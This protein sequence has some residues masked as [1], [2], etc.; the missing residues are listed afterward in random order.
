MRIHKDLWIV[1]RYIIPQ[2]W[3]AQRY[4]SKM[5]EE[6]HKM[7]NKVGVCGTFL[8]YFEENMLHHSDEM[9]AEIID[10]FFYEIRERNDTSI[11]KDSNWSTVVQYAKKYGV[12]DV[13]SGKV[14]KKSSN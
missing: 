11:M 4:I 3:K 12:E 10:S 1:L 2:A 13:P 7:E 14:S 8:H 9:N 5:E 6:I